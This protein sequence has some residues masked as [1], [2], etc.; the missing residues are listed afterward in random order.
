MRRMVF[1]FLLAG[2][3]A[4]CSTMGTGPTMEQVAASDDAQCLS[5]GFKPATDSYANCR[6]QLQQTRAQN[7]RAAYAA[8]QNSQQR[9]Q[10]Q[11]A[12]VMQAP[13]KTSINCNSMAMGNMVNTSCY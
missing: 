2:T 3:M 1:V 9:Y 8:W 4:G 11:S 10:P 5:Y 12:F 13:P 6:M 7:A